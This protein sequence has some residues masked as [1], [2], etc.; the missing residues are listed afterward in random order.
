MVFVT[1]DFLQALLYN[2]FIRDS[3]ISKSKEG[4]RYEETYFSRG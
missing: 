1:L 3:V 2:I 4:G